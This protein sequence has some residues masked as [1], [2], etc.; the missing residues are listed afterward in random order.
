M[1]HKSRSSDGHFALD[2]II[3]GVRKQDDRRRRW[4]TDNVGAV[5]G[6]MWSASNCMQEH[7][8]PFDHSYIQ[9]NPMQLQSQRN[10]LLTSSPFGVVVSLIDVVLVVL[11]RKVSDR[12]RARQAY[13]LGDC[14][15]QLDG[16]VFLH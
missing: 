12:Y 15:D 3:P 4:A 11:E 6:V 7:M 2:E 8:A 5:V 13:R 10:V 14:G 1:G 9:T 16:G